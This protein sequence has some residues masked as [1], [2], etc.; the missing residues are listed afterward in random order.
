MKKMLIALALT[1]LLGKATSQGIYQPVTPTAYGSNNLRGVFRTALLLPS[2]CGVPGF[3][4]LY[5]V[6]SSRFALYG[7]TCN[8][9]FYY[10][11]PRTRQ[12]LLSGN[13][14][15][16]WDSVTGKPF[17]FPTTYAISNDVRDSIQSRV[18][19]FG[20]QSVGGLKIFADSIKTL[21]VSITATADS[22]ILFR[23]PSELKTLYRENS[24]YPNNFG[25]NIVNSQSNS[26]FTFTEEGLA[27]QAYYK[28]DGDGNTNIWGV[29]SKLN[30]DTGWIPRIVVNQ[31]GFIGIGTNAPLNELTVNGNLSVIGAN[32]SIT[33]RGSL[34]LV[35]GSFQSDNTGTFFGT[36]TN[37]PLFF[38]INGAEVARISTD[39]NWLIKSSINNG[40]DALQIT[41]TSLTRGRA[42]ILAPSLGEYFRAGG[43]TSS[44]RSLRF[45]SYTIGGVAGVGHQINAPNA[46]ANLALAVGG[47][48]RLTIFETGVAGF[49]N[50]VQATQFRLTALNTAPSSATDTGLIGEIRIDA[51]FIYICTATNTWKRVAIS[52]W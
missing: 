3:M 33:T 50:R 12:W 32:N 22:S 2:G 49:S 17:N 21:G 5:S 31:N 19:T 23:Y 24:L 48:D 52:T 11:N 28:G 25:F 45:T 18:N 10:Y 13:T 30:T 8:N 41:G 36:N 6:D 44:D 29:S 40:I 35:T 1:F 47:V 7:D 27:H 42:E 26:F 20:P 14:S 39:G 34:G 51:N 43:G 38:R 16:P 46:N 37:H 15:I 9:K 4:S